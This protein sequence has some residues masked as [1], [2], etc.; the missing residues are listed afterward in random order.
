MNKENHAA[1]TIVMKSNSNNEG[2][3]NDKGLNW[4]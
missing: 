3:L 4:G 1:N 2:K